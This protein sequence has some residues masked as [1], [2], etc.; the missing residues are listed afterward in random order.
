[1]IAGQYL[2]RAIHSAGWSIHCI[3]EFAQHCRPVS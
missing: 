3:D 2:A 1:V